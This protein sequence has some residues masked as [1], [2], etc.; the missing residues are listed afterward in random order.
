MPQPRTHAVDIP[1]CPKWCN[2]GLHD[3]DEDHVDHRSDPRVFETRRLCSG[4]LPRFEFSFHRG[5]EITAPYPENIG[6]VEME[7]RIVADPSMIA[8]DDDGNPVL[9]GAWTSIHDMRALAA[10]LLTMADEG[11]PHNLN[12]EPIEWHTPE[13]QPLLGLER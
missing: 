13:R 5:D 6:T 8:A 7:V 3:E 9:G 4:D 12:G 11:D 1:P 10:W 2:P